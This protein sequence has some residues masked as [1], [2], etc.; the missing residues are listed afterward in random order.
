MLPNILNPCQA[1]NG[2]HFIVQVSEYITIY[3]RIGG[4]HVLHLKEVLIGKVYDA[5]LPSWWKAHTKAPQIILIV[6]QQSAMKTSNMKATNPHVSSLPICCCLNSNTKLDD[7]SSQG[8]DML[9]DD[10]AY[11]RHMFEDKQQS[12]SH[13]LMVVVAHSIML[14]TVAL[15]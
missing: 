2:Q 8:A 13:P 1:P 14:S 11:Q 9:E 4:R 12:I 3:I 6:T 15:L 10:F 5:E 7:R